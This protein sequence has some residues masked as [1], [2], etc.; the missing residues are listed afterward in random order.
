VCVLFAAASPFGK[1]STLSLVES[2]GMMSTAGAKLIPRKQHTNST[3]FAAR[4]WTSQWRQLVLS[5]CVWGEPFSGCRGCRGFIAENLR[6]CIQRCYC[7]S[8][9]GALHHR[10]KQQGPATTA[11]CYVVSL[12]Q[13][14]RRM[15]PGK[16]LLLKCRTAE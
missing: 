3:E 13:A 4:L 16:D 2:P 14:L 12:S 6:H 1:C 15:K 9:R 5:L 10:Q 7:W 11:T 8:S